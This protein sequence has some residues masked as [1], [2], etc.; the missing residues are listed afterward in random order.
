MIHEAAGS[1]PTSALRAC[2][3]T[4]QRRRSLEDPEIRA[5]ASRE[6]GVSEKPQEKE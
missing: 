4:P 1:P 2:F 6:A 3:F 5:G